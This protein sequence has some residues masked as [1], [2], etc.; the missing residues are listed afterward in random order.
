MFE[1]IFDPWVKSKEDLEVEKDVTGLHKEDTGKIMSKT[2]SS[3]VFDKQKVKVDHIDKEG[4]LETDVLKQEEQMKELKQKVPLPL[5]RF[6]TTHKPKF[7]QYIKD[8]TNTARVMREDRQE[9]K[10]LP[11]KPYLK[12]IED[13]DI[14]YLVNLAISRNRESEVIG[15]KKLNIEV[16]TC[17]Y[18]K[19]LRIK[20]D[21]PEDELI[22]ESARPN[23]VVEK[24]TIERTF[25]SFFESISEQNHLKQQGIFKDIE[26][27][28]ITSAGS[29]DY[30]VGYAIEVCYVK[31]IDYQ[32]WRRGKESYDDLT[33]ASLEEDYQNELLIDDKKLKKEAEKD[34]EKKAGDE[35]ALQ[36][37][38]ALEELE[39]IENR[40][41][42][43]NSINNLTHA[44]EDE[45]FGGDEAGDNTGGMGDEQPQNSDPV[46]DF[47]GD[48]GG[49][50]E[51]SSDEEGMDDGMGGGFG[52]DEE[53]GDEF[54]QDGGEQQEEETNEDKKT[55]PGMHPFAEL[56]GK[57]EVIVQL[58]ELQ[59]QVNRITESLKT[60]DQIDKVF[61]EKF[62]KLDE[63][64]EDAVKVAT[65]VNMEDSLL[66]YS[67]YLTHFEKLTEILKKKLEQQHSTKPKN[68]KN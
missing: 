11:L 47:A 2:V 7:I 48:S 45:G 55:Q 18:E 66:R 39:A 40:I 12:I 4:K 65:S 38:E 67:M 68:E 3:N 1:N 63:M 53:G 5:F 61:I 50:D 59:V 32:N 26:V 20:N 57:K 28:L 46:D 34:A 15:E 42:E 37:K 52:G 10:W 21:I 43:Q 56:N 23:Y 29:T 19:K 44:Q 64:I 14:D 41:K 35:F 9:A 54:G 22:D 33:F 60:N 31:P 27:N 17:F 6:D 8:I 16:V 51:M 25:K 30:G 49:G 36:T 13:G 24:Q 58:Q 62:E